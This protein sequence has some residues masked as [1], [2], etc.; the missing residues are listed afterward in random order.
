MKTQDWGQKTNRNEPENEVEKLLKIRS[1]GN[2]EPETNR[3]AKLPILLKTLECQ[4]SVSE[5]N[6]DK[7]QFKC[8]LLVFDS[9]PV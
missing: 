1:C 9:L 6:L 3:R 4:K 7:I 5:T 2:N 8:S